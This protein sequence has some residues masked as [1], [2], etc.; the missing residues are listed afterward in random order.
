MCDESHEWKIYKTRDEIID[1]DKLC[2]Y[3]HYIVTMVK[4]TFLDDVLIKLHPAGVMDNGSQK[5]ISGRGKYYIIISNIDETETRSS[6]KSYWWKE[7][8]EIAQRFDKRSFTE[9]LKFWDMWKL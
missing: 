8:I 5:Q 4:E 3:G 7:A 1:Q 2:P 6:I 9:G